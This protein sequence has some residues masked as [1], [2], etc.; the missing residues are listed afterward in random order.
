MPLPLLVHSLIEVNPLISGLGPVPYAPI[1]IGF[2]GAPEREG[3]NVP[4]N[5]S[6][7]LNNIL[8]PGLKLGKAELTFEIDCQGV[9]D[10]SPFEESLP[11]ELT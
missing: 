4:L 9:A 7:L 10:E 6:P 2:V 11:D 5:V 1:I 8:S 3:F